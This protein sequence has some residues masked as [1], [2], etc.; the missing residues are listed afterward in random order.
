MRFP[1]LFKNRPRHGPATDD[2]S[3]EFP[4]GWLP[5][6]HSTYGVCECQ[7]VISNTPKGKNNT[8]KDQ[9]SEG[10]TAGLRNR[11]WG[12]RETCFEQ[13]SLTPL[14]CT[15]W[16][17]LVETTR[18]PFAPRPTYWVLPIQK[19]SVSRGSP[20]INANTAM[21]LTSTVTVFRWIG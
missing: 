16:H 4:D 17:H 14:Q 8:L 12:T 13:W 19:L 15:L 5:L 18:R 3:D 21:Y 6:N 7:H 9:E 11:K 20:C 2:R 10:A 1:S